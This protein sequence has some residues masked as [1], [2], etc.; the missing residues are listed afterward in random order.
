MIQGLPHDLHRMC[1][2]FLMRTIAGQLPPLRGGGH[3]PLRD[4]FGAVAMGFRNC[5]ESNGKY[6][7]SS[8]L[9]TPCYFLAV[10]LVIPL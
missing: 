2:K 4:T 9:G 10:F 6:W 3:W 7:V 8:D 5:F 1:P